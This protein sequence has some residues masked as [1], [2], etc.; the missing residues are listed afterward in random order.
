M[1]GFETK[2]FTLS[3]L[4]HYVVTS[5]GDVT[6]VDKY[7][8]QGQMQ[9]RSELGEGTSFQPHHLPP[10]PIAASTILF[11]ICFSITQI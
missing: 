3:D 5:G 10:P 7:G 9:I 2:F 6:E 11:V 8:N 1:M 4:V